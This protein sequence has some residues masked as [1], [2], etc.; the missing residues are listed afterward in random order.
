M[1]NPNFIGPS[2]PP[3]IAHLPLDIVPEEIRYLF[4]IGHPTNSVIGFET[5]EY[6]ICNN[7]A[8]PKSIE[9]LTVFKQ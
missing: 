2:I 6:S 4:P 7:K 5:V 1:K 3:R 8:V 9:T